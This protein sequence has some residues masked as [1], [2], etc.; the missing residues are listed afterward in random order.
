MDN[1]RH[2]AAYAFLKSS[3]VT[4]GARLYCRAAELREAIRQY[5]RHNFL[6]YPC[7]QAASLNAALAATPGAR[8]ANVKQ[9]RGNV[10]TM[11]VDGLHVE[12]PAGPDPS[13]IPAGPQTA[14]R[15]ETAVRPETPQEASPVVL[16]KDVQRMLQQ[17]LCGSEVEVATPC[18]R[19]D[20][21]LHSLKT[22]VEIKA[23]RNWC[24]GLGQVLAYGG[25][26]P[27]YHRVLQLFGPLP[28]GV[29]LQRI[30]DT[31]GAHGVQVW[32]WPHSQPE[33]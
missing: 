18:G 13:L 27:A 7:L 30:K 24:H 9:K 16:E 6:S 21:V 3:H 31:C 28:T 1:G 33:S 11:F 23:A 29:S 4:Y 2:A 14:A 15:P 20:L 32:I 10:V 17:Q 12:I 22:V 8:L 25:H 19:A 5:A 26:F